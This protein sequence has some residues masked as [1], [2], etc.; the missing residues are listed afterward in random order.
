MSDP[1]HPPRLTKKG[2]SLVV[3]STPPTIR[4]EILDDA[5]VDENDDDDSDFGT[6]CTRASV[7]IH[8][9]NVQEVEILASKNTR[10]EHQI[11]PSMIADI[12]VVNESLLRYKV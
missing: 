1:P 5:N 6:P 3:T 2:Y 4:T 7:M 11:I 12:L 9:P 10:N 8:P